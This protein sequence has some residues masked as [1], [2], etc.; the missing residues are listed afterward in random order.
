M[1][2]A[3]R[4]ETESGPR[5]AITNVSIQLF[6]KQ[7]YTGTSMR[8]IANAVGLLP[9]SLYAHI[10]SKEA[11]L[12]GIVADGIGRFIAAVEPFVDSSGSPVARLRKMIV[13]HLE[14]VADNPERSQVVFHQW[15][16]LGT[17][18]LPEA[19]ERRRHYEALFINTIEA[20]VAAGEF[21]PD[22]NRRIVVLTILGAL[23]WSAEWFSPDGKLSA[24]QVGELMAESLLT[25]ILA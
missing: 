22:L 2:L 10:A 23:N 25:G 12:L 14:V 21:K 15:R 17:D 9:G 20:G 5:A 4:N 1:A 6:G 18:N 19:I 3:P 13:A 7:G 24:A 16:F 11:L 8:D